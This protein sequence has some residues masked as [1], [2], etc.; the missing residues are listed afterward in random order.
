MVID[1]HCHIT[2]PGSRMPDP[3]GHYYRP[4]VPISPAT[5]LLGTWAH[6]A[7]DTIA[8]RWR[9]AQ[10][11]KTY[12][13]LGPFIYTEMSRR[14]TVTDASTLLGEMAANGINQAVVVA[15]DP[16][17][18]TMEILQACSRLHGVLFPFGSVD[19]HTTDYLDRFDAVLDMPIAGLKFHSDLQNLPIDSPRMAALMERLSRSEHVDVPVYL[20][21]G[22]FPIYRPLDSP[23]ERALPQ[24][25]RSFP[26]IKFICGHSGWDNPKAALKAALAC[27]NLYLETSW[28]PPQLIRRLCDKLGPERLI[29]GSDF[30]LYS[31]ARAL[32]NVKIA[33]TPEEF[34]LVTYHNAHNLLRKTAD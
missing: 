5:N 7:V 15:I 29:F 6:D 28:Q 9:T 8:E 1:F 23:W 34:D 19:P 31:Q 12:R 32:K 2:T 33:L 24:L 11:L 13:S 4:I 16:L 14:M 20:H 27:P 25:V 21:T 3:D 22:N 30:P 26:E 17:V 18:P 10:A